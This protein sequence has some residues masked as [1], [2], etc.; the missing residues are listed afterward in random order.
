MS[1]N[2]KKNSSS[3]LASTI[4]SKEST[5]S[6][7]SVG[8]S[9]GLPV[10]AVAGPTRVNRHDVHPAPADF[11]SA[12]FLTQTAMKDSTTPTI[13]SKTKKTHTEVPTAREAYEVEFMKKRDQAKQARLEAM[14]VE[15]PEHPKDI[16]KD[17]GH[18]EHK[19]KKSCVS[20][21]DL[22]FTYANLQT[23]GSVHGRKTIGTGS[24]APNGCGLM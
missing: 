9:A 19:H 23:S 11:T 5:N 8:D 2:L 22:D 1:L 4:S 3:S 6:R 18:K 16:E 10:P 17:S 24:G 21:I 20:S 7:F 13:S 12:D 14:T 15:E